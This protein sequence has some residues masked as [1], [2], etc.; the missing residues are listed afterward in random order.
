MTVL[1]DAYA[2]KGTAAL[3]TADTGQV[4]Q[5]DGSGDAN[6]TPSIIDNKVTNTTVA[7]GA[8][9]GYFEFENP[10]VNQLGASWTFTSHTTGAGA[11]GLLIFSSSVTARITNNV[12]TAAA[13]D[14]PCHLSFGPS[15]WSYAVI[16]GGSF[17]VIGSGSYTALAAD[18]S[19]V[20]SASVL[21]R[22]N[23]ARVTLPNGNQT[24][25]TD[26]RIA[27]V[28]KGWPCFEIF[29]LNASTD[30]KAKFTEVWADSDPVLS[31]R[32]YRARHPRMRTR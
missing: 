7:A 16:D 30:P 18:D 19:T 21:L 25:I 24:T 15:T 28:A 13:P 22:A 6:S 14:A 26:S 31:P 27:S 1:S 17:V 2:G 12:F 9:A 11:A 10:N 20:H 4:W 23:G 8:R 29:A 3:T 32:R 5:V